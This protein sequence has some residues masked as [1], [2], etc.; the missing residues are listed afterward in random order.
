TNEIRK[1][2]AELD[3]DPAKANQVYSAIRALKVDYSFAYGGFVNHTLYF[4]ILGGQGEP[5][6]Q[7][8]DM[9]NRDFGSLENWKKDI[10]ATGLGGGESAVCG[11]CGALRGD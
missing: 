10:K 2:L 7:L 4:D 11:V 3:K 6:G 9:L 5:A 8:R 1:A